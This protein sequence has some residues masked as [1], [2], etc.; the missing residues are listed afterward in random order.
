VNHDTTRRSA[1]PASALEALERASAHARQAGVELIA[2][3]RAVVDA[4]S[5]GWSGQPSDANS[6]LAA[7]TASLDALS[8]RLGQGGTE[9]PEPIARAVLT[10]LDEE[11]ARWEKRST[12]DPDARAVLRAFLG[13]REILWELGVRPDDASARQRPGP[14][15]DASPDAGK[16]RRPLGSEPAV[17]A[18]RARSGGARRL[19]RVEVESQ[20]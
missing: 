7:L 19:S 4:V 17:K 6:A 18:D 15:R 1:P 10:A 12:T 16:R 5:L 20:R 14:A 9:L 11:I 2:A 8:E 3:A 13:I